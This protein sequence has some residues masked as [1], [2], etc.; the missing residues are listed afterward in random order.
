MRA[1]IAIKKIRTLLLGLLAMVLIVLASLSAIVETE[2]GSRWFIS[3]AAALAG[4]DVQGVSGNLRKGLDIA[5]L[6]Y[7]ADAQSYRAQQLSFRWRPVDLLY[8][9]LAIQSLRAGSVTIKLPPA[10]EKKSAEPF[11]QWPHL[12]LPLRIYLQQA[13]INHIQLQQGDTYQHWQQLSGSLSW[14]TFNVRYNNLALVHA[15]YSLQLTGATEL[16][17]PYVTRATAHWLWQAAKQNTVPPA[18]IARPVTAAPVIP[19]IFSPA[20]F[21]T[22]VVSPSIVSS[23]I[24]SPSIASASPIALIARPV[25]AALV[26]SGVSEISGDLKTMQLTANTR[27]PV[28]LAAT[29][30]ANLVDKKNQLL[31]A[32]LLQL[33]AHWQQQTLPAHWWLAGRPVPV[34]SGELQARGNWKNYQASLQGDLHLPQAPILGV[35]AKASGDWEKIHLDFLRV[36]ERH[37]S[38]ATQASTSKATVSSAVS[39]ATSAAAATLV[40]SDA[41]LHVQGDVR[42]L[43]QLDWQLAVQAE[44]VNLAS[45]LVDWPSN[46]NASFSTRGANSLSGWNLQVQ[47]LKVDGD[48]RGLNLQ[49]G[50]NLD[51]DEKNLHSDNLFFIIGANQLHVKGDLGEAFNLEWNINAPLLQQLD[52]SVQGSV[53]SKGKLQGDAKNPKL[54]IDTSITQFTW[55]NYAVENLQLAL[56]PKTRPNPGPINARAVVQPAV[57]LSATVA[58]SVLAALGDENYALTFAAKQLRVAGNRFSSLIINGDGSINHHQLQALIK[59]TTYGRADIKIRGEYQDAQWQGQFEQLAVKLK[60]VPRWWLTSSKPVRINRDAVMIDRQ[61]LTTRSN[62]TGQV[63]KISA[64]AQEQVIGEWMPNQSFSKHNYSWLIS[65]PKLPASPVETYSLPQLCMEGEWAST[66]GARV[67]ANLD[68]VPL[69]QFLSLFKVEVFFA[70]VMDG[71]LQASTPDFSLANTR[72]SARVATRNAELRYQYAGGTTE[73]YPWRNF[74][75][76]AQLQQ[77]QLTTSGAME[78][79]GYGQINANAQLDLLQKKINNSNLIARFSNLAPLETLLPFANDVKGDF[80]ADVT[81]GGTF[82]QPY[83]LGNVSLHKGVAN[84]PRLGIDLTDIELQINSSKAGAINMV[85]QLQSDKGRL[86]LVADLNRFGTPDWNLQGYINGSDFNVVSLP[87]LKATLSPDIKITATSGLMELTGS[88]VIPWA[89]ANIKSLPETA[90]QVSADVVIV[91]EQ[92]AQDEP[93]ARLKVLTNL[94]LSLGDDVQFNGFGLN[95]KLAG[96]INL[97]KES[98]RQFFTSGFVSVVDGSY[99]AYGQTLTIDR[100]RL[101]FQGPYENPGLE[102]RASR[103]IRDEYDTKV[104]LDISGTLQRPKATVFSSRSLSDSQA[105]MMLLTGKPLSE[106]SKADASLLVSAV[107]GL[108][109]DSGASITSEISRFFHV[110]ELAI[111]ADQGLEQSEL[112]VGKYLTPRLLVRYVVGIF[113][114]A[115]SLGVEYQLTERLRIEAES[116]ETQ[117]V[118]VVY[119]IER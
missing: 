74:S 67:N 88:A 35:S 1:A 86:S 78:W 117:S 111:K 53:L 25:P 89:R 20:F 82:A 14:G 34:T 56:F 93:A 105:M 22:S 7:R 99:K 94:N 66:T 42:W 63:E 16:A 92:F 91:D 4:I 24:A 38:P 10:A 84:L 109:M 21:S 44:Q 103:S 76:Q 46:I 72:A 31:T 37:L 106:A 41:G 100:G 108:G 85:S 43:P 32:P 19:A 97:L 64:V 48:L 13:Q 36:R 65:Q 104:G 112:W 110:D 60:N 59:H 80:L 90:T 77:G 69:R 33:T 101:L 3:R 5:S 58:A 70:G 96:K 107:S 114:Q 40:D 87:E 83:L 52:G 12:R 51:Y 113:D 23:S 18:S 102:I 79:T 75:V 9:A 55:G 8:G 28:V 54:D 73:V 26:Y 11:S 57:P 17:F 115:F 49:A 118:D 27:S 95:S 2:T 6:E 50:G 29:L 47:D 62:L 61:C 119:K 116:G 68:S 81:L 45:L 30:N 98:Q 39:A 15:D 71:S